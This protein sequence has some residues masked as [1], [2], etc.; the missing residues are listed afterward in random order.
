MCLFLALRLKQVYI[1]LDRITRI[2]PTDGC[3]ACRFETPASAHTRVCRARFNSLVRPEKIPT[4]PRPGWGLQLAVGFVV[5]RPQELSDLTAGMTEG[6]RCSLHGETED[7][8][9]HFQQVSCQVKGTRS[10]L[11]GFTPVEMVLRWGM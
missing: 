6:S 7:D 5:F 4:K 1:A 10:S 8:P 11:A 2:G 9:V 3:R